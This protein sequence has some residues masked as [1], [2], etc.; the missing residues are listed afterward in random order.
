[1][2]GLVTDI[3]TKKLCELQKLHIEE[4]YIDNFRWQTITERNSFVLNMVNDLSAKQMKIVYSFASMIED[5]SNPKPLEMNIRDLL[6]VLGLTH[7]GENRKRLKDELLDL[8]SKSFWVNT[9]MDDNKKAESAVGIVDKVDVTS[10][11]C[12]LTFSSY[13]YEQLGFENGDYYTPLLGTILALKQKYIMSLYR[14]LAAEAYKGSTSISID[15]LRRITECTNKFLNDREFTRSVVK[16]GVD[17]INQF[18]D[19]SV[20]FKKFKKSGKTAGYTFFIMGKTRYESMLAMLAAK[21][22][23]EGRH[24]TIEDYLND[25]SKKHQL[26]ELGAVFGE[27]KSSEN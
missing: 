9:V 17:K 15:E 2:E 11:D 23:I 7:G 27:K 20:T 6:S 5:F 21:C 12:Y 16:N 8:R 14:F 26:E 25:L 1:M 24:I 22:E 4:K 10:T 18:G 13:M 19:I 3:S